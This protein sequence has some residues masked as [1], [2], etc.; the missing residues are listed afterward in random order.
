MFSGLESAVPEILLGANKTKD[1]IGYRDAYRSSYRR[2]NALGLPVCAF[3]IHGMARRTHVGSPD[4]TGHRFE[5]NPD[6]LEDSV[7]SLEFAVRELDPT[8]LSMNVLRFIPGVPFSDAPAFGFLRPVSGR[9]HGGYFDEAWLAANGIEDPRAF[10][11]ILRAFE[12]AGSPIPRHMTPNR[13][14][15]ILRNAVGIVNAKNRELFRNQTHIVVDPWF[16]SRFLTERWNGNALQYELASFE[17][18]DAEAVP[19]AHVPVAPTPES[20]TSLA[21]GHL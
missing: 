3:L 2:K 12:G 19:V 11:P 14:Y 8:Y 5:W 18:I 20:R 7:A 10:H 6:T 16:K 21:I 1:P 17:T 15:D 9:L 13:C 4:D